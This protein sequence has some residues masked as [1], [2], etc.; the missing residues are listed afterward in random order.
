MYQTFQA[1]T[2]SL[3]VTTHKQVLESMDIYERRSKDNTGFETREQGEKRKYLEPI[4]PIINSQDGRGS[5]P[6]TRHNS[7]NQISIS[8]SLL[9]CQ[10]FSH[11]RRQDLVL[12]NIF[13]LFF[14]LILEM[15]TNWFRLIFNYKTN[16]KACFSWNFESIV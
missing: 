3:P 14:L 2:L 9:S 7:C 5:N 11:A 1:K 15:G 16:S 8:F 4:K 13:R 12:V 10:S 6:Q